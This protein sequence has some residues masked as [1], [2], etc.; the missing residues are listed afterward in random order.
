MLVDIIKHSLVPSKPYRHKE[1]VRRNARNGVIVVKHITDVPDLRPLLMDGRSKIYLEWIQPQ[2]GNGS[3]GGGVVCLVRC[4]CI[5]LGVCC[6]RKTL[7]SSD[8]LFGL[9]W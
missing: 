7:P 3:N 8:A 4:H 5:K 6:R 9:D 2:L 1:I